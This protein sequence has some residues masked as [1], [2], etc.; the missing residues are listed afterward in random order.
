MRLHHI[1]LCVS[2]YFGSAF[3]S[4]CCVLFFYSKAPTICL[5]FWNNLRLC[6]NCS[7]HK[8]HVNRQQLNPF[9]PAAVYFLFCTVISFLM[10]TQAHSAMCSLSLLLSLSLYLCFLSFWLFLYFVT[11]FLVLPHFFDHSLCVVFIWFLFCHN[12]IRFVRF[13][14]IE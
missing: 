9:S 13:H 2:F 8:Y 1:F 12:S 11:S 3:L 14:K 5:L 10:N 7:V 6:A 4:R